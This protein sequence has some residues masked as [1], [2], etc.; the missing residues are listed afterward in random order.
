MSAPIDIVAALVL[1]AFV[2][3]A[4]AVV[5][6]LVPSTLNDRME[7]LGAARTLGEPR[8]GGI[9]GGVAG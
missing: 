2:L 6:G 9:V 3:L 7:L 8:N 5:A 4:V 1:A